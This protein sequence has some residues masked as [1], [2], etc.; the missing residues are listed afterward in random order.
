[1]HQQFVQLSHCLLLIG[2]SRA[3]S[4]PRSYHPVRCKGTS[5]YALQ[6]LKP[7]RNT[8]N[9]NAILN[10]V[11]K[12]SDANSNSLI[13]GLR[14]VMQVDLNMKLDD[15]LSSGSQEQ[16]S[17]VNDSSS[18]SQLILIGGTALVLA[19]AFA[20]G[21]SMSNDLGLDLE[22]RWVL[23]CLLKFTIVLLLMKIE[24]FAFWKSE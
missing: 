24:Q 17:E 21:V 15:S 9:D 4:R 10:T 8:E 13:N 7:R 22:W 16:L 23:I 20:L 11:D 5:C 1:M 3:F 6:S 14:P 12:E 19:A 2:Q 18:S